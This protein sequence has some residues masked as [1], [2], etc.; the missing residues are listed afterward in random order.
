VRGEAIVKPLI[1]ALDDEA[2]SVREAAAVALAEAVAARSGKPGPLAEAIPPLIQILRPR[3][4]QQVSG[5]RF[6]AMK[7]RE[8]SCAV[9]RALAEMG[10]KAV[11]AL[12]QALGD[13]DAHVRIGALEALQAMEARARGAVPALVERLRDRDDEVRV[14]AVMALDRIGPA[15]KDAVPALARALEDRAVRRWAVHAL[16]RIGEPSL[17]I[18]LDSWGKGDA[19]HQADIAYALSDMGPRAR[20]ALPLLIEALRDEHTPLCLAAA[21]AVD[22]LGAAG[23]PAVP[24]LIPLLRRKDASLREAVA[25]TLGRLGPDATAAIPALLTALGDEYPMVRLRAA[26]ALGKMGPAAKYAVA[27]D[28][29]PPRG[30]CRDAEDRGPSVVGDRSCRRPQGGDS[31]P[32]CGG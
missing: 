9:S 16:G 28:R 4:E 18:L 12:V 15:A 11:A 22:R 20:A 30:R 2:I 26:E 6:R 27:P 21:H 14:N 13:E 19:S 3:R 31:P 24:N 32:A 8:L 7:E 23:R 25:Q 29:R 5:N 17:P 1:A 10:G